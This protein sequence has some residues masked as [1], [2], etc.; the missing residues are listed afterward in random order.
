MADEP[1]TEAEVDT[2]LDRLATSSRV[3]GD[4]IV[5]FVDRDS[6]RPALEAFLA[7]GARDGDERQRGHPDVPMVAVGTRSR[8]RRSSW[9]SSMRCR[10]GCARRCARAC[11]IDPPGAFAVHLRRGMTV[12]AAVAYIRDFDQKHAA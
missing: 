3:E 1:I 12:D 7:Q 11:S 6:V 10:L 8:R 5:V 9:P 4:E 2:V